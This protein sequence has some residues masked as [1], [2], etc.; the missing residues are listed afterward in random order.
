MSHHLDSPL[1][2]KDPR[3]NITDQYV[4][5]DA[6]TTVFVVNVRTSLAGDAVPPGFHPEG[7]Y[8]IKVHLDG[9]PTEN[10]AFRWTFGPA[11][12][13]GGQLYQIV[14]LDGAAAG[15]D[16]ATGVPIAGGRTGEE[17]TGDSGVRAW[18]GPALDPFFLDLRQLAAVDALVQRAED[19]DPLAFAAGQATDTFAGSTVHSLVL[20]VPQT[21]HDLFTGRLVRV[22]ARTV[23]ATDSGGWHQVGRAGLPM[24]WPI[25][26]DAESEAASHANETHPGDDQANYGN[27]I[28]G[29]VAATVRRLGTSRRPEAYAEEVVSRLVPDSLPYRIGTP[30]IFGFTGFNGRRLGDNAP[31]VMFSLVMNRAVTTGLGSRP[32][33]GFPYVT[34]APDAPS[35]RPGPS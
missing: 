14:R 28:R 25:F 6:G 34:P 13:G 27:A 21:D 17:V 22:W 15:S 16:Q 1:A 12:G 20:R 11:G 32:V 4:F 35:G 8:E 2:R 9:A 29:A 19:A 30:A 26:R 31:E 33:G 23:L 3:L 7:R 5:D 10:L 18:A 24:I